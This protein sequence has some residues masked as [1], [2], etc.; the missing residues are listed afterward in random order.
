VKDGVN[1]TGECVC[2]AGALY[3]RYGNLGKVDGKDRHAR[4][5]DDG[6]VSAEAFESISLSKSRILFTNGD[7]SRIFDA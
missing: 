5:A 6:S 2:K 4:L 1:G 7:I 3:R